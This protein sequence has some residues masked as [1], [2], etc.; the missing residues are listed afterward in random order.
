ME[1]FQFFFFFLVAVKYHKGGGREDRRESFLVEGGKQ[2]PFHGNRPPPLHPWSETIEQWP[3]FWIELQFFIG[4]NV[5]V[6]LYSPIEREFSFA[7]GGEED[8]DGRVGELSPSGAACLRACWKFAWLV[9]DDVSTHERARLC[10]PRRRWW[11]FH[12][13]A[14]FDLLFSVFFFFCVCFYRLKVCPDKVGTLVGPMLKGE[15][16]CIA[17]IIIAKLFTRVLW[18]LIRN[19]FS[20]KFVPSC[21]WILFLFRSMVTLRFTWNIFKREK[22]K[23]INTNATPLKTSSRSLRRRKGIIF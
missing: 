15:Y 6:P 1:N 13:A 20:L 17:G 22:Q 2:K 19:N 14:S 8:G 21:W 12:F 18:N 11:L 5:R 16:A 9:D 3:N 4:S 23:R 10:S 7:P